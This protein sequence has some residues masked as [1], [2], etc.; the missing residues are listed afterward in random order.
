MI[1]WSRT[2]LISWNLHSRIRKIAHITLMNT[3]TSNLQIS[4]FHLVYS[5]S[6]ISAER[7][8]CSKSIDISTYIHKHPV[9]PEVHSLRRRANARNVSFRIYIRWP[10]HIINPVHNSCW[11]ARKIRSGMQEW[12]HLVSTKFTWL[13]SF[14]FFIF[15]GEALRGSS[16]FFTIARKKPKF[17]GYKIGDMRSRL[18]FL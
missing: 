15:A 7:N 11:L 4:I 5:A 13:F 12:P 6:L 17:V 18:C 3:S 16:L 1:S 10:I 8:Y 2:W 9:M 14:F